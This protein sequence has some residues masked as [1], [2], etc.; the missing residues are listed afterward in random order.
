[1]VESHSVLAQEVVKRNLMSLKELG[2]PVSFVSA[3]HTGLLQLALS[4]SQVILNNH[5][6]Q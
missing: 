3:L 5:P 1:V 4:M 2:F 6:Y